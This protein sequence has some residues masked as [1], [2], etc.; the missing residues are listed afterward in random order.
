MNDHKPLPDKTLELVAAR[1]RVL[2]EPA[3]LR[4]LQSL[5]AG[6]LPVGALVE[7]LDLQQAN[8]SKH[9]QLLHRAGLVERRR[10]GLQVIYRIADPSIF[11]LCDLVCGSLEAQLEGALRAARGEDPA[12][13][14]Q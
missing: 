1:F 8:V 2:A 4:I 11:Q 9:L 13:D 7:Q 5:Q 12:E 14:N 10:E 3:R 6:E